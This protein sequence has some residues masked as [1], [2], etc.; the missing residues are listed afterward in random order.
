MDAHAMKRPYTA[1]GLMSG[2]SMDGVDAS[3][4]ESDGETVFYFGPVVSRP[5]TKE[6]RK[7][8][9]SCLE[10][11]PQLQNRSDRS[12]IL[13]DADLVV[14]L[15]HAEVIKTLRKKTGSEKHI[16]V[17][18]FHGQTIFH[19]P[20]RHLTIQLGNGDML[21][22]ETNID[23]VF[24]FRAHDMEEGGQG[25]PFAPVYHQALAKSALIEKPVVFLNTGGVANITWLGENEEMIAF[26]T[27]PAN[28]LIDDLMLE[29]TGQP[30]DKDGRTASQGVV[31]RQILQKMLQH[32]YLEMPPPKSLDRN[33]F[34]SYAVAELSLEDAAATLT[35]FTAET[36]AMGIQ[37]C[38]SNVSK[39]IVCGGGSRNPM[40]MRMIAEKTGAD[41][42][43]STAY[44][45]DPQAIEAQAFGF[46][47]I[48]ALR[49]LPISFP[50]TTGVHSPMTG[51]VLAKA[52]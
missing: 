39:I 43:P 21:A 51:G 13:K 19:A 16:D 41:V 9:R 25:A 52:C 11:A 17:I 27:G 31:N 20:E 50:G 10:I 24:D 23:V 18:G 6:E 38:P 32:P 49:G 5:Y 48:R 12:G 34:D 4:I 36:I 46:F 8:L 42:V 37:Q 47:A 15:A 7:L 2:T 3:I 35:A 26:D 44:G 1:I 22:R 45:W 30:Y 33:A 29:R 40:M 14:T 28:A